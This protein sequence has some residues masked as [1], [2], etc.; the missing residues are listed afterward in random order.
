MKKF[1]IDDEEMASYDYNMSNPFYCYYWDELS[2]FQY[3]IKV[4][5]YDDE[6]DVVASAERDV[7]AFIW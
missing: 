2:F 3:T 6:G 7:S 1:Y 5:A 4:V